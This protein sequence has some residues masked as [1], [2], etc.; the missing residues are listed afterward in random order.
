[1]RF[2]VRLSVLVIAVLGSFSMSMAQPPPIQTGQAIISELRLRG[3]NGTAD[4]FIEIYNN[5]NAAIVVQ[6]TDASAGWAVVVSDGQITGAVCTIVNGV[7]IPARGHF[8]CANPDGYSLSAYP[9]GNANNIPNNTLKSDNLV[10]PVSPFAPTTPDQNITIDI[11]DGFGVALFS[12]TNGTNFTA[13]TRLDAFGFTNSPALYKEGSGFATVP[14]ANIEHT[15]FRDM[16]TGGLPRDTGNNATD[17][18][19]V[20]T[21]SSILTNHLGAP[22]PENLNSPITNNATINI[23]LLDPNVG[24]NVAPNREKSPVV[25]PNANLG[26][27]RL[28]R[29]YKN[30]TGQPVSRLRFRVVDITTRGTPPSEC[31]STCA[32]VRALTSDDGQAGLSNQTIVNVSGVTLEQ[33]PTQPDGGG[34]NASLSNNDITLQTPLAPGASVNI[35]FKLGIMSNG[36]F[37]YLVNVEALNGSVVIVN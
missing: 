13:A 36:F 33:P 22:G 16:R 6:A 15:I 31:P 25:E 28:R 14:T 24:A 5:T 27:L 8:L 1:M 32:D 37:R 17:F 3:P 29:T 2:F 23:S 21:T 9:G 30:N 11:P 35:E 34:L 19:L 10:V 4:E 26:T 20:A 7:I 18:R 12:T